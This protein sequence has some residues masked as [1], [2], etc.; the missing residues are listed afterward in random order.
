MEPLFISHSWFSPRFT[1]H[2][3]L[4]GLF[5]AAGGDGSSGFVITGIDPRG[6]AALS[7]SAAGDVN[8]DGIGFAIGAVVSNSSTM[9]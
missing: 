6:G 8:A 3:P 2:E 1:A 7:V 5:P 4:G 9:D